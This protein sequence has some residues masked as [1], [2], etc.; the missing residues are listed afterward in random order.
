M[1]MWLIINDKT[2]LQPFVKERSRREDFGHLSD[3]YF[4]TSQQTGL[5]VT[6]LM[7]TEIWLALRIL[8]HIGGQKQTPFLSPL[9]IG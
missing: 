2:F 7:R 5:L 3:I 6:P 9:S 8:F 4:I 1:K